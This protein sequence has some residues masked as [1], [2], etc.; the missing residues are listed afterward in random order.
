MKITIYVNHRSEE[1]LSEKEYLEWIESNLKEAVDHDRYDFDHFLEYEKGYSCV[2]VFNLT[3]SEKEKVLNEFRAYVRKQ[4]KNDLEED[5]KKYEI[6][7]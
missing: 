4:I 6:E 7:I 1:L 5:W 3:S 2:Y